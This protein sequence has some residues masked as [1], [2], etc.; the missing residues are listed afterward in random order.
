MI[1]GGPVIVPTPYDFKYYHGLD[2][3]DK[4]EEGFYDDYDPYDNIEITKSFPNMGP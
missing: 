4:I 2:L 1:K 3:Y